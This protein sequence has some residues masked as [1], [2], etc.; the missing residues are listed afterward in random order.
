MESIDNN[1]SIYLFGSFINK[2]QANDIDI[3]ITYDLLNLD[4]NYQLILSIKR[5]IGT[6]LELQYGLPVHFT[7]LSYNELQECTSFKTCEYTQLY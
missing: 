7:T 3:L 5:M 6:I 4:T 2:D 1:I